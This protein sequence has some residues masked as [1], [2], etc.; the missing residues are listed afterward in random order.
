MDWRYDALC[1]RTDEIRSNKVHF[2]AVSTM[3]VVV[4]LDDTLQSDRV[5]DAT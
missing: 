3:P 4:E 5:D 2:C 1:W